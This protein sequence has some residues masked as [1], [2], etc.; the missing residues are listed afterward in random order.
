MELPDAPAYRQASDRAK[1]VMGAYSGVMD[2]F[3][4]GL[5]GLYIALADFPSVLFGWAW[6]REDR[7]FELHFGFFT[8]GY[9][10]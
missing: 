4:Y 10:F 2:K 1:D 8:V 9:Q 3:E 7:C 6:Y 5:N